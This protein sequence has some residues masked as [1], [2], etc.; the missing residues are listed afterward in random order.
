[1]FG[2]PPIPVQPGETHEALLR[3]R[4]LFAL[5]AH[6][7]EEAG[8]TVETEQVN[9]QEKRP[10]PVRTIGRSIPRAR[11]RRCNSTAVKCSPREPGE[12]VQYLADI[13]RARA[14]CR[15][16]A[17]IERY[18]VRE[19]GINFHHISGAAQELRSRSSG[20][21]RRTPTRDRHDLQENL[22]KRFD[23]LDQAAR[24]QAVPDRADKD[25][26]VADAYLFTVLRSGRSQIEIDLGKW[27]NLKRPCSGCAS[28]RGQRCRRR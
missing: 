24:R 2:A 3:P 1:M 20:R 14:G 21:P 22:G 16:P 28:R 18:R 19:S 12:S 10:S 27:P 6:R 15:R 9:N 17:P 25:F 23:W 8:I 26:T 11:S 13:A 7:V 5:P 4:R